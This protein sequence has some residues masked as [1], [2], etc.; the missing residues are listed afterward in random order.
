M[1]RSFLTAKKK[2]AD[3]TSKCVGEV[4]RWGEVLQ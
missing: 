3:K 4:G 1:Y 2:E